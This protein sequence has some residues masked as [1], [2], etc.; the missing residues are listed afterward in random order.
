M[1]VTIIGENKLMNINE[2]HVG[3]DY[4]LVT[5]K[6]VNHKNGDSHTEVRIENGKRAKVIS[7]GT[8][9]TVTVQ[10]ETTGRFLFKY[11]R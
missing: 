10:E 3:V 6:E 2:K 7:T 4:D 1:T 8:Y 11:N 5:I 9:S